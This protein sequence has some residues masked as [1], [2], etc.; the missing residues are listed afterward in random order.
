M[1]FIKLMFPL[2]KISVVFYFIHLFLGQYLWKEYNW[3][4]TDIS[5][6]TADG[7][8]NAELLRIFTLIYGFCFVLF[9]FGAVIKSFKDYGLIL[10]I[11]FSIFFLMAITSAVGYNLFPLSADKN[12]MNFQNKM[13]LIVTIIVVITTMLS[14]YL[15]SFGFLKRENT[16]TIGKITLLAAIIITISGAFNPIVLTKGWDVLGLTE[17]IVIFTLQ[18]YV[19]YLSFVFSRPNNC[20]F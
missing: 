3:I 13:H 2:G 5:S 6:L 10:R 18:F 12:L 14:L 15:I 17:R 4:T 20:R 7:A 1:K 9:T 8:P 16:K 11:G 19:F